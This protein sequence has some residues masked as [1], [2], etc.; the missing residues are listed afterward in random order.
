MWPKWLRSSSSAL[1]N[2]KTRGRPSRGARVKPRVEM[3]EA[4]TLLSQATFDYDSSTDPLGRVVTVHFDQTLSVSAPWDRFR[5]DANATRPLMRDGSAFVADVNGDG[6][7]DLVVSDFDST[8]T[9]YPGLPGKPSRFG[10]GSYLRYATST[11]AD[12]PFYSLDNASQWTSGD[13]GDLNGDGT[14]EL[15]LG[16]N[17]YSVTGSPSQPRLQKQ[18]TFSVGG[19]DRAPAVGDLNGDGKPDVVLTVTGGSTYV[20]WNT[21]TGG[22][23][24]FS[25]AQLLY[26]WTGSGGWARTA[27]S[28]HLCLGDLNGDGL[29]DLAGPAGIYFNTGTPTSPSFNFATATPWNKTGGPDWLAQSD[30]PPRVY[31]TDANGDGLLDAYFSNPASTLD[32]VLYYQNKG[33][34]QSPL[35]EYQ[36]PVTV[37]GT[38]A[39]LYYFGQTGPNFSGNRATISAVDFDG[40]GQPEVSAI[41]WG[42]NGNTTLWGVPGSGGRTDFAFQDTYTYPVLTKVSTPPNDALFKP[43]GRSDLFANADAVL[44]GAWA[45]A[46]GDGLADL[47]GYTDPSGNGQANL[48]LY[49]RS[50]T[51]PFRLA[52]G[53]P[54]KTTSGAQVTVAGVNL[55]DIDRDGHLDLLTGTPNGQL[56]YYRNTATNGTFAFAD[57]LPL[58]DA[59]GAP[60]YAGVNPSAPIQ[61]SWPTAID[62]NGDGNLDFLVGVQGGRIRQ[63]ICQTPGSRSGYVL[64]PDLLGTP[65]QN[66]LGLTHVIGG[67]S[68]APSLATIDIDH[69]GRP[70]VVMGDDSGRVWLLHNV[71]TG[72][73][74]SFALEPLEITRTTAAD[75]EVVDAHTVRLYFAV[76]VSPDALISF[77][78]VPTGTGPISGTAAYVNALTAAITPVTPD[79]RTTPVSSIT[80]TFSAPVTGFDLADL[81]LTRNGS[82][83]ALTGASLT[84]TD[85]ATWT[86]GNLSALTGPLG[87][88]VLTLTAAGSGITDAAGN[89]LAADAS[90]SWA[91]VAPPSVQAVQVND[92]DVQRSMVNSLAV[93]FSE[94]VTLSA[95]AFE[96]RDAA[97]NLVPATITVTTQVVGGHTVATLTF[98]G[99]VIIGGSLA[100]GRYTLTVRADKVTTAA[101]TM[102]ADYVFGFYRLFGDGNGD[103]VVDVDDLLAFAAAY[104]TGSGAPGYLWY[105]DSNGDGV[106]DVDDLLAFADRYGS[107]V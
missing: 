1:G 78:D 63:L 100:D 97:G 45:D 105:F 53:V 43:P 58:T 101:G 13:L 85:N 84:S 37:S 40:N 61:N 3:L 50:G 20:F 28:N 2:G 87:S 35:L 90:D 12:D 65:E 49:I 42:F 106:I 62:L 31:L 93:T 66:P 86:L 4:R 80:I 19:L 15:I 21:S 107:G 98:S 82:P 26:T 9:V 11:A 76:P 56:L 27:A 6:V 73:T 44:V 5:F 38:P 79:P 57:P 59:S 52:A 72:G 10:P 92:G 95:G 94:V 22:T 83:V 69:D 17:V 33:T 96:L 30:Q 25:A 60:I 104:G 8:V 71:G 89:P 7:G 74:A 102:A 99:T 51:M 29:L 23:I 16:R 18:Y 64:L 55:V 103:G 39:N 36:G 70:D 88:Y 47:F 91:V 32:Q 68:T 77:H 67:S 14:K 24:S 48:Q 81:S 34:R 41:G 75:L 46:N 54:V